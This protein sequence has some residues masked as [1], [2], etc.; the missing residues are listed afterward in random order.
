MR[1]TLFASLA[2]CVVA[3]VAAHGTSAD[4]S[5]PKVAI[6][7][8]IQKI[9][10]GYFDPSPRPGALQELTYQTYESFSYSQ[11]SRTLLKRAIVYLPYGYQKDQA[12]SRGLPAL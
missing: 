3:Q 5:R 1:K 4:A 11:K 10:D 2:L 7:Q 9:P 12:E 6:P 8:D